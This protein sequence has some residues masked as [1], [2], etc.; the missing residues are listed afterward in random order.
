MLAAGN[1]EKVQKGRDILIW[2]TIGLVIIFSAY[3]VILFVFEGLG[4]Q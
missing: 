1:N 4:V 2:A 3:A